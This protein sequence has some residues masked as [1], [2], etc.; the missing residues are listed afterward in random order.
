MKVQGVQHWHY[1]S[2][3]ITDCSGK[4][5][6]SGK[7]CFQATVIRVEWFGEPI[8]KLGSKAMGFVA[9]L[10]KCQTVLPMSGK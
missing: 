5:V 10:A 2:Q 6:W 9:L 4:L 3:Q 1:S 8:G 7:R